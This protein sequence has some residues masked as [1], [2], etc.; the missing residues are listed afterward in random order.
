VDSEHEELL[1]QLLEEVRRLREETTA[2]LRELLVK[3][4]SIER[5]QYS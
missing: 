1:R 2:L 4:E 3:L 5:S